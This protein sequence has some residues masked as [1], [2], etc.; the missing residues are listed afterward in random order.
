MIHESFNRLEQLG[1]EEG[2]SYLN[3]FEVI[4][5]ASVFMIF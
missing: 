5:Y 4:H 3:H 2:L 1:A